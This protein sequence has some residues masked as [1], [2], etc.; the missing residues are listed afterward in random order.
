MKKIILA[1]I[2]IVIWSCVKSKNE[3]KETDK[4]TPKTEAIENI[5]TNK[6]NGLNYVK[7]FMKEGEQFRPSERE[8]FIIKYQNNSSTGGFFIYDLLN[9]KIK[10]FNEFSN[11]KLND[12]VL[13]FDYKQVTL[14]FLTTGDYTY[15]T[16]QAEIYNQ[17]MQVKKQKLADDV[18]L[19]DW[20]DIENSDEYNKIDELPKEALEQLPELAEFINLKTIVPNINVPM[21]S[22]IRG[23]LI[24]E[25]NINVIKELLGEPDETFNKN[26]LEW[27][28]YFFSV[29]KNNK[30]G[31]LVI[32]FQRFHP[33]V[34][35]EVTFYS[36]GDKINLGYSYFISPTT[37]K[38]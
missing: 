20:N 9:P 24:Q 3:N 36:P 22:E 28:V 5:E 7:I 11:N 26:T 32:R 18:E 31:H 10:D 30:L 17:F 27:Y 15:Y 34:I 4:S 6:Q 21:Y 14:D 29:Q 12:E 13:D 38:Q 33:Q 16:A 25:T 1:T 8:G 19:T 2:L 23:S 37:P 35:D